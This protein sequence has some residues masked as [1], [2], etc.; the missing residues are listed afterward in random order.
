MLESGR[1]HRPA[2]SEVSVVDDFITAECLMD[3]FL[4]TSS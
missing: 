1:S 4:L 2:E 3:L